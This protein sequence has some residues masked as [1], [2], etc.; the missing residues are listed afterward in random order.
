MNPKTLLLIIG[1]LFPFCVLSVIGWHSSAR[2]SQSA[3]EREMLTWSKTWYEPGGGPETDDERLAR[4]SMAMSTVESLRS[5][6]FTRA[7]TQALVATAWRFESALDYHVHGGEKSPIGHQDN[8]TSR[9]L[10]QIKHLARWWTRDEW[11]AL[12]GRDEDATDRCARATLRVFEYHFDRCR[13]AG[14]IARGRRSLTAHDVAVLFNA[15]AD[16]HSCD[17]GRK[18]RV[19]AFLRLRGA[20]VN[21]GGA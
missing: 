2:G 18:A 19:T 13:R 4:W 5:E 9:C 1:L 7:D 10:G 6:I 8:G 11:M 15:Y 12:A 3:L 17:E 21:G 20:L 14:T 16:G